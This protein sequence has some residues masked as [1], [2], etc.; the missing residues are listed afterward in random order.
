MRFVLQV[1]KLVNYTLNRINYKKKLVTPFLGH[2][3][4]AKEICKLIETVADNSSNVL[5][6]GERGTGKRLFAEN[7]HF[8]R[9]DNLQEF[10]VVNCRLSGDDF[11][12]KLEAL[13]NNLLV[14]S[15]NVKTVF[16]ENID[17]LDV[18]LQQKVLIFLKGISS[19]N[20]S[21][22]II[23]STETFLEQK[24]QS[25]LFDR[26]LYYFISSIVLNF[27]PLRSRKEDICLIADFYKKHFERKSGIVFNDFSD[28]VIEAMKNAFW[29]GNVDELINSI[30]RAFVVGKND[31]ISVQD[32]GLQTSEALDVSNINLQDKSLKTA[33]D[34]F[35]REY[36]KKILEENGWNQTKTAKI[37]GIQ[38]TY[39][40]RLINEL[41]IR[42]K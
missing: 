16:F 5:L 39:V 29:P 25:N 35:K 4:Y 22:R 8:K 10:F 40:I 32:L 24:V 42:D 1:E 34:S 20:C 6:F 9:N 38:R 17:K 31:V 15:E 2:S 26:D 12:S 27:L 36:V 30:Q 41:Q 21:V 33:I 11:F 37:L 28:D 14:Q 18:L 23:S 3:D 13:K 7:V 19:S